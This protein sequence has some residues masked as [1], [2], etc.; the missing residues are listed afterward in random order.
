MHSD[1]LINSRKDG[2]YCADL[3]LSPLGWLLWLLASDTT[4]TFR[5]VP[6]GQFGR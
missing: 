2:I 5:H 1:A 4:F 6:S 3:L